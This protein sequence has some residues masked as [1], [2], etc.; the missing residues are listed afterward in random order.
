MYTMRSIRIDP[1]ISVS[2]NVLSSQG[3]KSNRLAVGL[4]L[5]K[6]GL[7]NNL[8]NN[9]VDV[10]LSSYSGSIA[11]TDDEWKAE[12]DRVFTLL[13]S[14]SGGANLFSAEFASVPNIKRL[15][16]W[17]AT[18]WAPA[19]LRSYDIAGIRVGARP[20]YAVQSSDDTVEVVWQE[21]VNFNSVVSGKMII[22]ITEKGM[23]A[24]RGAGDPSA[25]FGSLSKKPLPGEDALV[26]SLGDAAAQA[27]EKGLAVK[28]RTLRVVWIPRWMLLLMTFE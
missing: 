27:V 2:G 20:V 10:A 19:V 26:R 4:A 17:M 18:K 5:T 25:G 9:P 3:S 7:S 22:S 23:T 28:V 13:S 6:I 16:E 1:T 14:P 11:P 8:P 24:S 21:L 12:F 15:G